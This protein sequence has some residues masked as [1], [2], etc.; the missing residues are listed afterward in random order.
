MGIWAVCKILAVTDCA[1]VNMGVQ[2]WL[3]CD[4]FNSDGMIPRRGI[5]GS[6]GTSS[7]SCFSDL[8][9]TN[10]ILVVTV[11]MPTGSEEVPLFPTAL[12]VCVV[13]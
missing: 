13:G 3:W 10:F 5:A 4:V 8:R 2:R 7:F 9:K 11:F 6:K 12:S 1:A